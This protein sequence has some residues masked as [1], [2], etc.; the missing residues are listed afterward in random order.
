MTIL[1]VKEH[2]EELLNIPVT[3]QKLLLLGRALT[4]DKTILSLSLKEGTKFTLFIKKPD[5]LNEIMLKFF[6]KYYTEQQSEL[7]TKDFMIDFEKK[8]NQYS[9][10]DLERIASSNIRDKK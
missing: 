7:L 5:P 10:D 1:D 2:L 8:M 9:L 6:R 3:H 4:D